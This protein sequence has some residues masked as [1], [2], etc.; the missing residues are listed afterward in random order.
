MPGSRSSNQRASAKIKRHMTEPV[1]YRAHRIQNRRSR[2]CE[3][4]VTL[5]RPIIPLRSRSNRPGQYATHDLSR[6]SRI[7]G[8]WSVF[9]PSFPADPNYG[10][11]HT[12]TADHGQRK[13][14]SHTSVPITK[15]TGA[16]PCRGRGE[17]IGSNLT[18]ANTE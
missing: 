12:P 15:L 5:S 17:S 18:C 10:G 3:A 2:F 7:N 1:L 16:T 11:A 9:F 14:D 8:L 13:P 6:P 4:R